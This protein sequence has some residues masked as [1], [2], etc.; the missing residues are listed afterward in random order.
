MCV[1]EDRRGACRGRGENSVVICGRGRGGSQ[2]CPKERK[3]RG[4]QF[5]SFSS[6][7]P[8]L[9]FSLSL[10]VSTSDVSARTSDWFQVECTTAGP[11]ASSPVRQGVGVCVCV[12]A[13]ARACCTPVEATHSATSP[14]PL[15]FSLPILWDVRTIR[16][17]HR[18]RPMLR[19]GTPTLSDN[20]GQVSK[21]IS[22][23]SGVSIER[24]RCNDDR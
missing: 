18:T 17:R 16:S 9:S 14:R 10:S 8:I 1:S 21:A 7:Y 5:R 23:I 3:L 20:L 2:A 24:H 15:T 13:Y 6:S 11:P 22:K 12:Y 19:T 4:P